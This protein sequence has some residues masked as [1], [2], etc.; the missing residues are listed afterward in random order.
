VSPFFI[1]TRETT[2]ADYRLISFISPQTWKATTDPMLFG[3]WCTYTPQPQPADPG[4]THAKLSVNCINFLTA[5]LFCQKRGSELPTEAQFEKAASSGDERAYPWGGDS[6]G[7]EDAVWG[8]GGVGLV[9]G[10][11]RDCRTDP[12]IYGTHPAGSGKRD[13]VHLVDPAW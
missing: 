1:D 13:R 8:W 7:C 4:D 3:N 9:E 5:K 12:G 6:P 10:Y 11:S 2:V